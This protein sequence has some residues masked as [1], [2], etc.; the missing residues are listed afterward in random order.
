MQ[1]RCWDNFDLA[2]FALRRDYYTLTEILVLDA[3]IWPH[4]PLRLPCFQPPAKHHRWRGRRRLLF[5]HGRI[6][7][8]DSDEEADWTT[9]LSSI[10]TD[11]FKR[12][13]LVVTFKHIQTHANAGDV[14][15]N[16]VLLDVWC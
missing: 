16:L 6:P 1:H 13:R 9:G 11:A 5:T 10:L 14:L 4:V 3:H 2:A 8:T 12:G 7:P 15:K